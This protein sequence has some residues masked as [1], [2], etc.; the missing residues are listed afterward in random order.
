MM[1]SNRLKLG[2]RIIAPLLL[3][4]AIGAFLVA[5]WFATRTPAGLSEDDVVAIREHMQVRG[6]L[7]QTAEAFAEKY[8][9]DA[10]PV[11]IAM[12]QEIEE[13]SKEYD[14]GGELKG[15]ISFYLGKIGDPRALEPMV[16][17]IEGPLPKALRDNDEFD[18]IYFTMYGLGYLG[19]DD[20]L[21]YLKKLVSEDYW[22][23]RPVQPRIPHYKYDEAKTRWYLRKTA[24]FAISGGANEKAIKTLQELKSGAA[25]DLAAKADK[26]INQAIMRQ[27]G[28]H[29]LKREKVMPSTVT[30]EDEPGR[31]L[32][33]EQ[34]SR[35]VSSN[36]SLHQTD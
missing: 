29:L 34:A 5:R 24:L 11:L 33:L 16:K 13:I 10:V 1:L 23:K 26:A 31:L 20:A 22:L 2:V 9:A 4:V 18:A 32:N 17:I 8:G 7:E 30:Q 35:H 15:K 19:T 3:G 14:T 21:D 27:K 6:Y 36:H 12:L 28:L 25:A